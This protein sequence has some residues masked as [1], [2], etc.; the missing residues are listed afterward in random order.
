LNLPHEKNENKVSCKKLKTV[1]QFVITPDN[2]RFFHKSK[3]I[4]EYLMFFKSN[5]DLVGF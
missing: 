4:E 1:H 2:L 5:Y 3:N